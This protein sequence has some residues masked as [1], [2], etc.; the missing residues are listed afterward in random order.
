MKTL[1]LRRIMRKPNHITLSVAAC[2]AAAPALFAADQI[3]P[4]Q[5][6]WNAVYLELA[7][8]KTLPAELFA[9]QPV[10]MCAVWLPAKVKVASLTDPDAI[11]AKAAEWRVWQPESSPSAFLNNLHAIHGRTAMLI[12]ASAAASLTVS[13]Q[14]IFAR[15]EWIAPSFNFAGFDV[16]AAAPPT[17]A[18]FF[19]GSPAHA[20]RR[21][22]KLV[23][24]KWRAM[25]ATD[26]I[27][28]GA[29]YWVWCSAGSDFQGPV[30]IIGASSPTVLANGG[31]GASLTFTSSGTLPVNLTL[32]PSGTLPLLHADTP[33][34][35]PLALNP[36]IQG[37][38]SLRLRRVLDAAPDT[39]SSLLEVRGGGMHYRLPITGALPVS[40]TS[41]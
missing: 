30:D 24:G 41:N 33:F 11:P 12:K 2:M 16:D 21:I 17:V 28:R 27:Q 35:A 15:R 22:F 7:P 40:T 5:A 18:R 14:P 1:F 8:D 37:T 31:A 10:E 4:L 32:T 3:I 38:R 23:D 20:D 9:G 13:G 34:T 6:G 19:D 25:A 36:G 26:A 29:A 39:A